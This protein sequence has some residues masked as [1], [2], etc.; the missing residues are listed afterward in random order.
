MKA[1]RAPVRRMAA[2]CAPFM[3]I[4]YPWRSRTTRALLL[5]PVSRTQ[6]LMRRHRV[7]LGERPDKRREI[8]VCVAQGAADATVL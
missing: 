1:D 2:I 8:T 4:E 7:L 6:P 5:Q 3:R